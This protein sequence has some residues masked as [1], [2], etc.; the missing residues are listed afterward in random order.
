MGAT[1]GLAGDP[2][3]KAHA[4]AGNAHPG[5]LQGEVTL[6]AAVLIGS[7]MR[8][9]LDWMQRFVDRYGLRLAPHGKTTM[10]PALFR[11]QMERGAWGITVATAQQAAVAAA[12]GIGRVLMANQLVGRANIDLVADLL[13]AS[14]FEFFCLVD[15][16]DGVALLGQAMR[17]RGLTIDVLLELAPE[18]DQPGFRTGVRTEAAQAAVLDAIAAWHPHVRLAGVELY[19]GVLSDEQEIRRFLIR[20]VA[21]TEELARA[22][23]FGRTP[24]ILSGAGSAW[25]D[26]VADAFARLDPALG[27]EAVLRPG[28]YLTHDAGIYRASQDAILARNPIAASMREGLLPALQLWAC[29]QSIPD[30]TRAVVALGKRDVAFDAGYPIPIRHFRPGRDRQ[31]EDVPGHWAVTGMMDQHAYLSIAPD[32]AL[33]VGDLIGFDISHPCLTFDKWRSLLIVDDDYRAIERIETFF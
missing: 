8:H 20:A 21:V 4:V 12:N 28:C 1:M 9:N 31:P 23:R 7:A 25:Y 33:R 24:A 26:L 30:A 13:E 17:D 10:A 27:V 6:P 29:V 16:S 18:P 32:D 15:S 11:R 3:D 2:L 14:S 22:G 19:E 5:L